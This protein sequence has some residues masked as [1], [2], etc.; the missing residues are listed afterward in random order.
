MLQIT[1]GGRNN[2][3]LTAQ[4]C[5]T[6]SNTCTYTNIC[7]SSAQINMVTFR[8]LAR[9][10]KMPVQNSIFKISA[11]PDLATNLLT[12]LIPATFNS[13]LCQKGQFTLYLCPR[14][15]LVRKIFSYYTLKVKIE[16]SS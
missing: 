10:S 6:G 8:V 5:R 3:I 4:N 1:C 15:W 9:I 7:F 16:K 14:R 2:Y 12:I 11:H 13:L